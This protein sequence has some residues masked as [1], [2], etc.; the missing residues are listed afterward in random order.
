M[1]ERERYTPPPH[2]GSCTLF[3][4]GGRSGGR[5]VKGESEWG[6]GEEKGREE[7]ERRE[8]ERRGRGEGKRRNGERRR[9]EE[10]EEE[11]EMKRKGE[12]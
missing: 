11:E 1:N 9:E 2:T 7:G 6:E 8:G 3:G 10:E 5:G 12:N 4:W